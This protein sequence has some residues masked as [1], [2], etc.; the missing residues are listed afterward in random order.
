VFVHRGGK[1]IACIKNVTKNKAPLGEG[2]EK[3]RVGS[4]SSLRKGGGIRSEIRRK[5]V[6][7]RGGKRA[8][9]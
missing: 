7:F 5:V 2:A 3:P 1:E 4:S 8:K 6:R 9:G